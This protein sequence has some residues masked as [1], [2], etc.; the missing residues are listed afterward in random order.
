MALAVSL[1]L[2]AGLCC[3]C[4]DASVTISLPETGPVVVKLDYQ[5]SRL[6]ISLTGVEP[7]LEIQPLPVSLA[8]LEQ[9]AATFG[10]SLSQASEE[11][12][13]DGQRIQA[14]LSFPDL[15]SLVAF[16]NTPT[17]AAS[18]SATPTQGI[19]LQLLPPDRRF[20]PADGTAQAFLEATFP[21]AS[22]E[23]TLNLPSPPSSA[24]GFTVHGR[25]AQYRQG[26]IDLLFGGD[27]ISL[28]L[29][30]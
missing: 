14:T 16:I 7:W 24:R 22:L 17:I 11:T 26:T 9:R 3:S 25:Q 19:E 20:L 30:W 4:L 10:A 5:V 18:Y 1:A 27:T 13:L 2:V 8:G 6:L 12:L 23:L 15:A 21:S 29:D 28:A